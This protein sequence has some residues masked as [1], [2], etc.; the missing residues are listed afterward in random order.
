MDDDSD[1]RLA[2]LGAASRPSG[3]LTDAE[4][5]R[6]AHFCYL[7]ARRL[8]EDAR[9]LADRSPGHA[10]SLTVLALEELGKVPLLFEMHADAD[11]ERW[12]RYEP[13]P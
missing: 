11:S 2:S 4:I 8:L 10:L 13:R 1:D 12:R 6:G 3:P 7:N 9:V 5:A